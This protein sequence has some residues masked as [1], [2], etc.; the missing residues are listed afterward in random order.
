MVSH[1]VGDKIMSYLRQRKIFEIFAKSELSVDTDSVIISVNKNINS[2]KSMDRFIQKIENPSQ[3]IV[4]SM[5]E[6]TLTLIIPE[7]LVETAK[8]EFGKEVIDIDKNVGTI[9]IKCPRD[10][11]KTPGVITYV[12]SLF[13]DKNVTIY[14]MI[15]S[16]TDFAIVVNEKH[17]YKMASYIKKVF[18][19]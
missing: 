14:E 4:S 9:F 17:A 5:G 13:A 18:G 10:V 6:H 3:V 16:Y 11:S 2:I 7:L 1:S 8:S 12:S 19:C 15:L